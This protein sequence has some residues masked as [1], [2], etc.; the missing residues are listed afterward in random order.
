MV[1]QMNPGPSAFWTTGHAKGANSAN[2]NNGNRARRANMRLTQQV[3]GLCR[4][5]SG[6]RRKD[7]AIAA[8]AVL[9]TGA[10]IGGL[11]G[12]EGSQAGASASASLVLSTPL[13]VPMTV[14]RG[15]S[16]WKLAQRYGNP[17]TYILDRVDAIARANDLSA[18]AA[19]QPGQRLVVPVENPIEVARIQQHLALR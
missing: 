15:D 11:H 3:R 4:L 6:M 10:L 1:Q 7:I 13:R 19:L 12:R 5:C 9:F 18:T 16:L 2:R 14:R 17:R 8:A